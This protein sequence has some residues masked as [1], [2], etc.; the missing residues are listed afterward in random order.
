MFE[1]KYRDAMGRIGRFKNLETPL[2]L[3]V[4]N[5]KKQILSIDEIKK[6]GFKAI[7]TNSYIIY[8]DKELREQALKKGLHALLNFDGMIM[9]DSGSYQLYSYG[10]IEVS[11]EEIVRFQEKIKSDIGVI[12][13]IPSPPDVSYKR[14]LRDLEETYRR[15]RISRKLVKDMLLVGTVQGSTFPELR[16]ASAKKMAELDFDIYAIGGVVPVMEEYR[17]SKLVEIIFS[18]KKFIPLNKP[19]HLFGCGHPMV[20][21]LAVAL[22]CDIF[23]SASYALY[24]REGRYITQE[25]TL[26]LAE[27]LEFPCSCEVC[28]AYSPKELMK[29]EAGEREALLAKHNLYAC[30]QE[31]KRVKQAIY[32]GSLWELLQERCRGHARLLSALR[33]ILSYDFTSY[34]PV[35][36]KTAFFYGGEESLGRPEVKRHFKRL[37]NLTPGKKLVLLNKKNN[38]LSNEEYHV[39]IFSPIF[40]VIPT[41]IEDVYPLTQHEVPGFYESELKLAKEFVKEYAKRFKEV[42]TE[43]ELEGVEIQGSEVYKV[44]AIADYLFGKNVGD[45]L[46]NGEIRVERA[47]TGKIRRIYSKDTLLATLRPRDGFLIL[48]IEGAKRMLKLRYPKN[49]VVVDSRVEEFVKE[50]KNVFARFVVDADEEITPYQE[51]IVVNEED[52]LLATGTAILNAR[53]M[54][55]FNRG[56]AVKT[57]HCIKK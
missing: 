13:D 23:D 35:T 4:I 18:S 14:A 50:G 15:G 48:T 12:L 37:N 3:P 46:F 55:V 32:E 36:K 39:C 7:I 30:L 6:L 42:L 20:F 8:K 21:P 9:T 43:E 54:K 5:P 52:E 45:V 17:F 16:E 2:L 41:E 11:P 47:R 29:L 38:M 51:V 40:G 44:K 34:D 49:R 25:G 24:A 56:I 31:I 28:T 19:V 1:I 10:K 27:M 26:K 33:K 57:R 22:G 53:E